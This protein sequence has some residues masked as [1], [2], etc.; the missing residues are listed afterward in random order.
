MGTE[1]GILRRRLAAGEISL[2]QYREILR[3]LEPSAVSNDRKNA[4]DS[5][6]SPVVA[7]DD[8][9]FYPEVITK[10]DKV[11]LLADVVSVAGGSEKDSVN[12][13]RTGN[14]SWLTIGFSC[15]YEL[16]FTEDRL[17][18]GEARHKNIGL[19]LAHVRKAT[20]Q[21]R[22]NNLATQLAQRR[23]LEVYKGYQSVYLTYDGILEEGD[24]RVSIK[25]AKQ[26]GTFGVGSEWRSLGFSHGYNLQQV[27]ASEQKGTLGYIP[28][29]AI[30][31]VANAVDTD[32]FNA[33]IV[34][35]ALPDSKLVPR[36]S[37]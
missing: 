18:F 28:R 31:F 22:L 8:V 11:R 3:E 24:Q 17:Y 21:R 32:V 36:D 12:F 1:V 10:D 30:Q 20:F 2:E 4:A 19:A 23:R 13:V 29:K 37:S 9:N 15:G 34:W 7:V 16:K 25:V 6:G 35:L 33:L 27:V 26:S 5:L 14:S